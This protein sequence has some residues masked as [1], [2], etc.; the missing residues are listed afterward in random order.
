[1]SSFLLLAK[2]IR[3][4]SSVFAE[5]YWPSFFCTECVFPVLAAFVIYMMQANFAIKILYLCSYM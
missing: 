5:L 3:I 2:N 1:M 4:T